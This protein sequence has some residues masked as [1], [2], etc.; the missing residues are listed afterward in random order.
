MKAEEARRVARNGGKALNYFLVP[1]CYN[2]KRDEP[3][4]GD[5]QDYYVVPLIYGRLSQPKG[6]PKARQE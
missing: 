1:R 4:K 6:S 3:S 2:R 5:E